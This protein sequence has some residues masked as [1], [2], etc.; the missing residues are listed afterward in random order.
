MVRFEGLDVVL[1]GLLGIYCLPPREILWM[2]IRE[3]AEGKHAA[4]KGSLR[5]PR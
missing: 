1:A 5:Q 2:L 4:Y 3:I